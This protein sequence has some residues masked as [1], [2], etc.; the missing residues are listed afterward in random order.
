MAREVSLQSCSS[1]FANEMGRLFA[2]SWTNN[3]TGV[4]STI[5]ALVSD[6]IDFYNV[7]FEYSDGQELIVAS[8]QRPYTSI[9]EINKFRHVPLDKIVI[10]NRDYNNCAPEEDYFA[11]NIEEPSVSV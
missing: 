2:R 4:Y 3:R 1:L 6:R 11:V 7:K 8:Q 10:G 9:C 5:E